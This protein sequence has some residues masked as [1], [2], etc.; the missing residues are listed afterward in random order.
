[1]KAGTLASGTVRSNRKGFPVALE[2]NVDF[3]FCK[4]NIAEEGFVTAVHWKEKRNAYALSTIH[5]NAVE[6]DL[7]QKPK[8]VYL[9]VQ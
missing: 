7:L 3:R 6:D 4:V 1:M 2:R 8:L 5:G 9:R